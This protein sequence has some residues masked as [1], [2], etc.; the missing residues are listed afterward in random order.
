[1]AEQQTTMMGNSSQSKD[2]HGSD[3]NHVKNISM[4]TGDPREREEFAEK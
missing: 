2:K 4:F 3:V 1:M